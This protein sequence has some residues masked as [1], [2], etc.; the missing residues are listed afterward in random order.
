MGRRQRSTASNRRR[1]PSQAGPNR[2]PNRQVDAVEAPD[3]RAS[4]LE[5]R[6][7]LVS[8]PGRAVDRAIGT[9]AEIRGEEVPPS[10]LDLLA[11]AVYA[12]REL[13]A[14]IGEISF[15]DLGRRKLGQ[16]DRKYV[17]GVLLRL[18]AGNPHALPDAVLRGYFRTFVDSLPERLMTALELPQDNFDQRVVELPGVIPR[19][20]ER[21]DQTFLRLAGIEDIRGFQ[22]EFL[23]ALGDPFVSSGIR[24]FLPN[25]LIEGAFPSLAR[26]LDRCVDLTVP[27]AFDRHER[28]R[29]KISQFEQAGRRVGT[30]YAD[31]YLVR[32]A[33]VLSDDLERRFADSPLSHPARLRIGAPRK[34][35]PLHREGAEL[36]LQFILENHGAGP[37]RDV[38]VRFEE[39]GDVEPLDSDHFIGSVSPTGRRLVVPALVMQACDLASLTYEIEWLNADGAEETVC[40]EIVLPAQDPTIDWAAL[41]QLNPYPSQAIKDDRLLVG[42]DHLLNDLTGFVTGPEV[43]STRVSGEKRVGKSSLVRSLQA[44]LKRMPGARIVS[45]YV[46][47]NKLGVSEN[48]P[49]G[50]ISA[51]MRAIVRQLQQEHAELA[52]LT[53]PGL[54]DRAVEEFSEFLEDARA[55]LVG[56]RILIILDEFDELPNGAF[57]RGG[58]GDPFFRA[59][60]AFSSD[61]DCGFVLVGGERLELALSRQLDRLNAFREHRVDYIGEDQLEDFVELI[62]G[63]VRDFVEIDRDAIVDLH[64]RTAG[65]PFYSLL[66]CREALRKARATFDNHVTGVEIAEAYEA[67][68]A[69]APATA[70]A[71]VW[72]DYVFAETDVL[73]AIADRRLR[74]LLAWSACLREGPVTMSRLVEEGVK[75]ELDSVR[76]HQEV[77]E[78]VARGLVRQDEGVIYART[79]FIQDWLKDWGPER[80]RVDP[81]AAGAIAA[82]ER[83]EEAQRV[84]ADEIRD[85]RDSWPL[86]QSRRV[87][88]A[89]IRAWLDQF[90]GTHNQRLAFQVL[91]AV[92]LISNV[93]LRALFEAV[94]A[95]ARRGTT[96]RV[97]AD[98]RYRRE[99]AVVYAEGDGKSASLMAKQYAHANKIHSACVFAGVRLSQQLPESHYE[100]VVIVDDFVGTGGTAIARLAEHAD[101]IRD[102]AVR[103]ERPVIFGPACGFQQGILR[104]EDWI[105][106]EKLPVEVGYSEGDRR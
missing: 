91:Q 83:D 17:T 54:G 77:R 65:H 66:V 87:E 59:L 28:A 35:L 88:A 53:M 38:W 104:L 21:L 73:E 99:F 4:V 8:S 33:R 39:E 60:K 71:H 22:G 57:E 75:Y 84:R 37:A 81:T 56:G 78:F 46:D 105:S 27:D 98:K 30:D 85:L 55:K 61:G 89:D 6:E 96:I 11:T 93:E 92:R 72:F 25:D 36:E 18:L 50:A 9:A 62:S 3:R 68:L 24:P 34:R 74:V 86:Y 2:D 10:L 58:A 102:A 23:Q 31:K 95:Q 40:E 106:R 19:A 12:V 94:H 100:R 26:A 64:S 79:P 103:T 14:G 51:V 45:A 76:V 42:R 101:V 63:P 5:I 7:L 82:L 44:R 16:A 32:L 47:V 49:S 69:E 97:E 1:G 13:D 29:R 20:E 41:S 90:A 70:F 15:N 80:I 52:T 48:E 43:G 67:A